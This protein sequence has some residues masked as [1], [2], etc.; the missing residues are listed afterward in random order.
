MNLNNMTTIIEKLSFSF[1][2]PPPFKVTKFIQDKME[3][4]YPTPWE[5]TRD[6]QKG[7]ENTQ[8][9]TPKH[10]ILQNIIPQIITPIHAETT[11][12]HM[13]H[14]VVMSGWAVIICFSA[15]K[16]LFCLNSI[17]PATITIVTQ[18]IGIKDINNHLFPLELRLKLRKFIYR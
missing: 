12:V 8:E 14:T 2:P 17:S 1:P 6:K 5:Y 16:S 4:T 3:R 18:E 7:K 11:E 10:F 15:G 13:L 9:S